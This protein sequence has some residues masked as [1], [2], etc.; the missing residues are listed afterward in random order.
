MFIFAGGWKA[1][2]TGSGIVPGYWWHSLDCYYQC[3]QQNWAW[4]NYEILG[5]EGWGIEIS[6]KFWED[7]KP[8][9]SFVLGSCWGNITS[10]NIISGFCIKQN[11]K[12]LYE[13]S[14]FGFTIDQYIYLI[15]LQLSSIIVSIVMLENRYLSKHYNFSLLPCIQ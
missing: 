9:R 10:L 13:F 2:C 7:A 12:L 11:T 5:D 4:S 6:W 8:P 1:R 3:Y 14:H 15:C